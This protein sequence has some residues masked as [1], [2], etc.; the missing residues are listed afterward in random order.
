MP[1]LSSNRQCQ[2][3]DWNWEHW[4]CQGKSLTTCLIHSWST[5]WLLRRDVMLPLWCQYRYRNVIQTWKIYVLSVNLLCICLCLHIHDNNW[6]KQV[7]VLQV[8]HGIWSY[9]TGVCKVQLFVRTVESQCCS[10]GL[11]AAWQK[12]SYSVST[13][14]G[15][16]C[17]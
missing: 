6:V 1:I 10:A 13:Y 7:I 12:T 2:S 5:C 4:P 9:E 16:H 14:W 8:G 17:G 15:S 3:P 11:S